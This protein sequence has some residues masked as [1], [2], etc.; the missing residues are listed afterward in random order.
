MDSYRQ[1]L[2]A[3]GLSLERNTPAVPQDGHYYVVLNGEVKGRFKTLKL[4]IPLYKTLITETGWT[5]PEKP[6]ANLDPAA[7]AVERYMDELAAYWNSSHS[8]RRPG[9]KRA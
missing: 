3:I 8:H 2:A 5:P 4:A 6:K 7:E 1:S 9:V